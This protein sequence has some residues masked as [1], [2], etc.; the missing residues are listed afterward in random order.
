MKKKL[1]IV[2]INGLMISTLCSCSTN[3]SSAIA[4]IKFDVVEP[5]VPPTPE[6][7]QQQ[8]EFE[9]MEEESYKAK[10]K[11][12]N[13]STTDFTYKEKTGESGVE[14]SMGL[15]YTHREMAVP[16]LSQKDPKWASKTHDGETMSNTACGITSTAM[17]LQY[18]GVNVSP[19]DL[20]DW[21][22][23]NGYYNGNGSFWSLFKAAADHY[24]VKFQQ[25]SR[26]NPIGILDSLSNGRPVIASMSPGTFVRSGGHIIVLRGIDA[27]GRILVNDPYS[28]ELS[29]KSYPFSQIINESAIIGSECFWS[30]YR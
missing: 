24:G 12:T 9:K 26:N 22:Y 1:F 20:A 28:E 6:E 3:K 16:Y 14:D 7:K 11:I 19:P 18:A 15:K 21:A 27:Q 29:K 5:T 10:D 13:D 4:S 23:N 17:C 30:I 25:L 8:E 2:L